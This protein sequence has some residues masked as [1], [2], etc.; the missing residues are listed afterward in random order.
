M[1]ISHEHRYVFVEVPQTACTAISRELLERY[2]GK[3]ILKKHA[4]YVDFL[5]QATPSEREYFAFAGVRNP[6]DI[7]VSLY[8]K[9]KHN[10]KNQFTNPRAASNDGVIAFKH[11]YEFVQRTNADFPTF[12]KQFKTNIHNEYYLLRHRD[13]DFIVRFENLVGDF[14]EAVRRIGLTPERPLPQVNPTQGKGR[15]FWSYYTPE[16]RDQAVRSFGPYMQKWG[17]PLP[18]EWGPMPVPW[19][20]R[21]KFKTADAAAEL[22]ARHLGMSP[23]ALGPLGAARGLVRKVWA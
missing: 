3:R 10:H 9:L 1:V 5:K 23:N 6:L 22:A 7:A 15:D 18:P 11:Q 13:L 19:L 8:F 12:F 4:T 16:I 21:M 20:S 14:A 17:Y 2:A